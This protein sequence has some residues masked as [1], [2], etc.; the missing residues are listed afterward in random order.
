MWRRASIF[1]CVALC[2]PLLLLV[3]DRCFPPDLSRARTLSLE[4][5]DSAGQ[6]LNLS[7]SRDGMWRL[8]ATVPGVSPT[9]IDMLLAVEDKRFRHH[10]GV[11]PLAMLRAVW[12]LLSRGRVISG[13][14]TLTMQVARLLQPHPHDLAGKLCDMLRAMQLE[15][16]FDKN[17]I[18]S[19]YSTL[20]PFGG[21]IEGVRAASLLYF[22]HGPERLNTQEAA[23]LVALPQ[24]PTR[25]RPDRH[26]QTAV[27]AMRQIYA[28]A[29]LVAPDEIHAPQRRKR[30]F[31]A[32]YV[33][34]RL[35]EEHISGISRT[36]LDGKLQIKLEALARRETAYAGS[37]ADMAALVVRNTD[38][39][40][41]A[42]IGGANYFSRFGMIDLVRARRSP[43][44]ALKPFIYGDA[45][46][47]SL[48]VPDTLIDDAP[49]RIAD[50]APHDFDREFH[51]TVSATEALQQSYNLPAVALLDWI[52]PARFAA[53]LRQAGAHL[54]LPGGAAAT[55]PL[56]LG[57]VGV[58][59]WDMQ[60][61]YTGLGAKG[62]A[63]PLRLVRDDPLAPGVPI[64]TAKAAGQICRMLR[65]APVPDGISA[66]RVRQIA[67]KTGTSYGFR[68][69]WAF[70]VTPTLSAGVWIGRA[71][72]TPRP[73]AFARVVAAPVLFRL[74]DLLPEEA[75]VQEEAEPDPPGPR[76][77][78]LLRLP[79]RFHPA[80]FP[81]I[82]YPPSGAVLEF[83][84]GAGLALEAAGG[85][86]PYRWMINGLPLPQSGAGLSP[87]WLPDGPGFAHVTLTDA[88]ARSVDETVRV[89]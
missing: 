82:I 11:D 63:G 31:V 57:G 3:L 30:P 23:L 76:A 77:P 73:G 52:G 70:G 21:N 87:S 46:D 12:Q 62:I 64:M 34:D 89:R 36:M 2:V 44:S 66:D 24:S 35:R 14:S 78:S 33:A 51:G 74:F 4:M 71:D 43:G 69:A 28:R 86:K 8:P 25:R 5:Q 50:Y 54:L 68:D 60:M 79:G 61:L 29:S 67:Y 84:Q 18:L 85:T 16:R 40:V 32:P 39:A 55:L 88:A 1:A 42:Y 37:G 6:T 13:G 48:I 27:R 7:V 26:P 9:Y 72:G 10:A 59:L 22:G 17:T 56:A 53:G 81:R 15:S 80:D 20:A 58:N 41:L 49:L 75:P 47:S 19:L 38:R 83:H 65:N 45:L